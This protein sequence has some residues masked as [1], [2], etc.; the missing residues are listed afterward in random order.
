[1]IFFNIRKF[2]TF[3]IKYKKKFVPQT[4]NIYNYIGELN[5]NFLMILFNNHIGV[6]NICTYIAMQNYSVVSRVLELS[7]G[8]TADGCGETVRVPC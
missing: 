6:V 1:M 7:R 5:K 8:Q 3:L 4:S 2:N